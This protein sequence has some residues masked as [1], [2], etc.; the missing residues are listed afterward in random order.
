M[1]HSL[2]SKTLIKKAQFVFLSRADDLI[3]A[4][5]CENSGRLLPRLPSDCDLKAPSDSPARGRG[6]PGGEPVRAAVPTA[7]PLPENRRRLLMSQGQTI[8]VSIL[9]TKTASP[10]IGIGLGG[11][12]D[13]QFVVCG[14]P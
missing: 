2:P 8:W 11:A 3:I 14:L 9:V 13:L 5:L 4:R 12:V 10:Q 6:G 1:S 7:S